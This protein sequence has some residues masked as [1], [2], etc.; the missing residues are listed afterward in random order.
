MTFRMSECHF[1][2]VQFKNSIT[3]SHPMG[4][5]T[6]IVVDSDCLLFKWH[7]MELTWLSLTY[8]GLG[9]WWIRPFTSTSDTCADSFVAVIADWL[10]C[11]DCFDQKYCLY[12]LNQLHQLSWLLEWW[13]WLLLWKWQAF[14]ALSLL[15]LWVWLPSHDRRARGS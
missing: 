5:S 8:I 2:T 6:A 15:L 14:S 9:T 4:Q 13:G 10:A 12:H 7:T 11:L 3:S 1:L